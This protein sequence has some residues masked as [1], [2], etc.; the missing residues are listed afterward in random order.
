MLVW[1]TGLFVICQ[2]SADCL[3]NHVEVSQ[4]IAVNTIGEVILQK[5]GR[6]T[7]NTL[8]QSEV[9][10]GLEKPF[11]GASTIGVAGCR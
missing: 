11:N 5:S 6:V 7:E 2:A 9:L 1:P 8:P 4:E 10:V 3:A